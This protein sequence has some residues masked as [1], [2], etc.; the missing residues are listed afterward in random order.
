VSERVKMLDLD[1]P[2]SPP[3]EQLTPEQEEAK[4]KAEEEAKKRDRIRQI[5]FDGLPSRYRG[6]MGYRSRTRRYY[7]RNRRR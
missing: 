7:G 4:K 5:E 1:D 2:A 6:R 3:P